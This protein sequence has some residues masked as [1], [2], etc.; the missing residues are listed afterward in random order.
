MNSVV[1]TPET[2]QACVPVNADVNNEKSQHHIKYKP[3]SSGDAAP[4]V[5]HRAIDVPEAVSDA[6]MDQVTTY[7]TTVTIV[8]G[9]KNITKTIATDVED[10]IHS[11]PNACNPYLSWGGRFDSPDWVHF[12]LP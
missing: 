8:N 12:Q 6:L 4:H 7:T 1:F 2:K 5:E 11:A 3:S 9:K 10:Y